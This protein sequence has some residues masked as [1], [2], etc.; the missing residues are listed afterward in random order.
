MVR[1]VAKELLDLGDGGGRIHVAHDHQDG[2]A[3]GVPLLVKVAEHGAGGGVEGRPRA[4]RIMRIRGTGKHVAIQAIDE[5]V[6][7]VGEVA[8]Y[9]LFDG[10]AL[11]GPLCFG[12]IHTAQA[13]GLRLQRHIQI[14]GGHGGEDIA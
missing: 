8:G 3:R 1:N 10:A 13:G 7:G 14:G 9:L 11:M 4:Q 2:V 6:G 12:I 5:F